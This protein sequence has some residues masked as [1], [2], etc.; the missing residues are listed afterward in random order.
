MMRAVFGRRRWRRRRCCGGSAR[1]RKEAARRLRLHGPNPNVEDSML[2]KFL[3]K[4]F[5]LWEW[6]NIFPKYRNMICVILN[7]MSWVT[8]SSTVVSLTIAS[9]GQRSSMMS[10]AIYLLATSLTACLTVKLVVEYAKAP[11]EAKAYAPRAK[12]LR[13]GMWINVHA[14]N[15]VPGDIIF[16]K[17]GDIV[18]A[19]AR[20]L[21]F[22]KINTMTC[23]AKRSVDCVHGFLIYYAWTVSCGQGTAVVIATGRDIP[24]STLRLYPQRYTRPGQLKEGIMLVGCFCFSLVL[25]GTIAEVI[26]RLLFQKHSSGAMLQ[27]GCFMALIGVVPM[28]MPVVLYLA[29]AFGSLRLCLLGVASR[30]TVALEDLASMDVMLFNMTGTIKCNKPSF[31]RDKIELFAKGVNEDQAIVLASRASRSQHELYIEPIDPAILSLLD[32][33]EQ[34]RAGVQVIEHHAHFFVSLK[35]MFLATYI[36]ENGSKCC[37]F[38]GDPANASHLYNIH[39]T[40]KRVAHQCGCSKAVKERISMIMDNLAVDGYQ[41]IAVGHQSDSCWEFAGLLPFKEDLRHDSAD[42]LNGLISLGLDI[43]VL[44]E[45]PLL[46]TR[47]VCGRLGKL[48]INVLPAR[49]V[50]ELAR[51]NKEVHLNI[52]GISD[53]FPEDNSDIVRRLRNFGC[54]CAMVGHEFLDHDSIGE[55][56]IG[57]SVAD[58]TDYTKSESDLVLTQPAL[59]PISSAVQIS[60]EICQMMKGYMIYTVSSTVHLFGVHAI[61]LL[62]NFDLPSF[63]TLCK[64]EHKSLMDTDEEIRAA[65][66]LQMS[67][68]NQAVALFAY[69][70][71]CCHIRCPGPVVTFAFIFTQMVATRKAVGGD[72]DFA[73]AKGVGW[74]KAGLIWLYNFVLL[75]VPVDLSDMEA[76]KDD[77][78]KIVDEA[79]SHPTYNSALNSGG[80]SSYNKAATNF[81]SK[82]VSL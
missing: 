63:L 73:I 52:N 39:T 74:L 9:A 10:I 49:A 32:D 47:Q 21:R 57:I 28:A 78:R 26:L 15:L 76:C 64:I 17:V 80:D 65:L 61:L 35:L 44:T 81:S 58:A 45:S 48:G 82:L 22:E 46:V 29:L 1:G 54:R 5:S 68:V 12:V 37:V 16:L 56:H 13:D 62:W 69:S 14:V 33:P 23:W 79:F 53:L 2:R 19:N 8:V 27:G 70:D 72:L 36:D 31:A 43:I 7:S 50:F 6:N 67:I 25:F 24:R 18:P 3:M 77:W 66:F 60:R 59:I 38:K 71:D 11:L 55:S 20:V 34:A 42:A 40:E 51:N 30:G 41:A 4:L 75:F